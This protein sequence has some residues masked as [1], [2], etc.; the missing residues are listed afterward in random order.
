MKNI[1]KYVIFLEK[2]VKPAAAAE[3][4]GPLFGKLDIRIGKIVSAE[5]V[6]LLTTKFDL[7][8]II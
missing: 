5:K 1:L 7:V 6:N 4:D 3:N 2:G 8:S